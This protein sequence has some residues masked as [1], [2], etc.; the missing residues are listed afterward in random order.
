MCAPAPASRC[1]RVGGD[2]AKQRKAAQLENEVAQ[3][4]A[5]L[6]AAQQE[7]ERVKGRNLQVQGLVVCRRGKRGWGDD[8]TRQPAN[9]AP[10]Q[11]P[12][13]SWSAPRGSG[14]PSLGG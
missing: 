14:P 5:A 6:E 9:F 13:R 10:P 1:R 3:L 12:H 7:Y 4:E 11:C 2:A 8:A